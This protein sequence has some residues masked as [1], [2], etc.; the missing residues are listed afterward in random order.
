M[1][2]FGT[3]V[4]EDVSQ[5]CEQKDSEKCGCNMSYSRQYIKTKRKTLHNSFNLYY[6]SC[7]G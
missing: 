6:L 4:N 1:R 7:Q 5:N 3:K 2:S